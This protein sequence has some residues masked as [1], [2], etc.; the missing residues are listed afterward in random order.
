MGHRQTEDSGGSTVSEVGHA[1]HFSR[2]LL[3]PQLEL[4]LVL[5]TRVSSLGLKEPERTCLF[6]GPQIGGLA[7]LGLSTQVA[8]AVALNRILVGLASSSIL[9]AAINLQ[10]C[11]HHQQELRSWLA[12]CVTASALFCWL[13]ALGRL[14]VMSKG[15]LILL[16]KSSGLGILELPSCFWWPEIPYRCLKHQAI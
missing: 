15:L 11:L 2:G 7:G 4:H 13:D 6:P 8:G 12:L 1:G 14:P 16:V 5:G 3:Q 9:A 10:S